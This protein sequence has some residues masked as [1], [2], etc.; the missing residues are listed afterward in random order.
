MVDYGD[1]LMKAPD[2]M[3][4]DFVEPDSVEPDFFSLEGCNPPHN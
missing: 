1:I 3:K 4:P 2:S